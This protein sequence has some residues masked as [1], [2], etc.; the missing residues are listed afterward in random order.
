MISKD[1]FLL[2]NI[3]RN[4]KPTT[5]AL[6][7][8]FKYK[9]IFF[10]FPLRF[11]DCD[12]LSGVNIILLMDKKRGIVH[13]CSLNPIGRWGI[14]NN[15]RFLKDSH[16]ANIPA[17]IKLVEEQGMALSAESLIPGQPLNIQ[18]ADEAIFKKIARQMSLFYVTHKVD[19]NFDARAWFEKYEHVRVLFPL[20]YQEKLRQLKEGIIKT[21][22]SMNAGTGKVAH[23]YIHGDLTY[24]NIL[25]QQDKVL[26]FDFDRSGIDFPEFD[27][28]LFHFNKLT[29]QHRAA[30]YDIFFDYVLRFTQGKIS[31]ELLKD[32][33]ATNPDFNINQHMDPAIRHLFLYRT[34]LLSLY[35]LNHKDAFDLNRF[36]HVLRKF[37]SSARTI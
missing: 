36:D 31:A 33:Y 18:D 14:I 8:F 10:D 28:L 25:I 22:A 16:M 27:I 1:F 32:F 19:I 4:K 26:V 2:S 34:V 3:Y 29:H 35:D 6:S 7:D 17:P 23:T 11:N 13:R 30:S 21:L 37:E 20:A 15:Y 12:L 5:A 9:K 24:K